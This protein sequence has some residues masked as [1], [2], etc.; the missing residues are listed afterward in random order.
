[1]YDADFQ[2]K[3]DRKPKVSPIPISGLLAFPYSSLQKASPL[4][5]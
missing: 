5:S 2:N 4:K 3:K 1:M